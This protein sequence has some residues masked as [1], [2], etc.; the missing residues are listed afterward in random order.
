MQFWFTYPLS[1][2]Q[3]YYVLQDCL[4]ALYY[5]LYFLGKQCNADRLSGYGWGY[6]K[7]GEGVE[8][9]EGKDGTGCLSWICPVGNKSKHG[10]GKSDDTNPCGKKDGGKASPLQAFLTDCLPGFTCKELL[11]GG[12]YKTMLDKLRKD[13][14]KDSVYPSCYPEFLSHRGHT[15]VF[16]Q[17]CAVPMGFSGSFREKSEGGQPGQAAAGTANGSS[18]IG[19]GLQA[20]LAYYASSNISNASLYQIVRCI[21]SLT[22]RV[23]RSTGT[24]YGF[25]Y[26]LGQ[27]AFHRKKNEG[28]QEVNDYTFRDA[29]KDEMNCCP[30]WRD[31]TC[32]MDALMGWTE[33]D[34]ITKH[35]QNKDQGNYTLGS[36]HRCSN[37]DGNPSCGP[38]FQPLTG[39]L[40]NSVAPVF[41]ETYVSWIVHLTWRLQSGLQSLLDEFV[42]IDCSTSGCSTTGGSSSHCCKGGTDHGKECHCSDVVFC[43]G[44][45][46]LFYRFG[47]GYNSP[48]FLAGKID[49]GDKATRK[50][51]QFYDQLGNV[52]KGELFKK[53][54]AAINDFKYTTRLPFIALEKPWKL[55]G[56]SPENP[57]RWIPECETCLHHWILPGLWRQASVTGYCWCDLADGVADLLQGIESQLT[58]EEKKIVQNVL[59]VMGNIGGNNRIRDLIDNVASQLA[60]FIGYEESGGGGG[61]GSGVAGSAP[62]SKLTGKGIG[63]CGNKSGC[64]CGSGKSGC[65][66]KKYESKYTQSD[67]FDESLGGGDDSDD[68][69][70]TNKVREAK[71]RC[72]KILLGVIPFIFSGLSY[73]AWM[74]GSGKWNGNTFR[75][76]TKLL[77]HYISRMGYKWDQLAEKKDGK[78]VF[79]VIKSSGIL[80]KEDPKDKDYAQYLEKLRTEA[81]K[82]AQEESKE[83]KDKDKHSLLKL[84]ILCSGYFRS[85]HTIDSIRSSTP[86]L[87]RT[88][89]EILYWLT[90]LPYCPIYRTLVPKVQEMFR[91]NGGSDGSVTFYSSGKDCTITTDNCV[92][93]LLAAS[94]ASPFVLLTIQDTI[95]CLVGGSD[96]W[97]KKRTGDCSQGSP[98]AKSGNTSK[99]CPII[100]HDLYANSLFKFTYPL[101]ETQS[102]YLLQDNLFAL[103]YQ[104]YF[105]YKQGFWGISNGLGWGYCRYG[106]DVKCEN[107]SGWKCVAGAVSTHFSSKTV[108]GQDGNGKASP[109]QAFLC[110]CLPGF[111]CGEV[112]K[113]MKTHGKDIATKY[114]DCYMEFLEHRQ[115]VLDKPGQYCP[116]P[117]G[118]SGSFRKGTP[119]KSIGFQ[120]DGVVGLGINAGLYYYAQ[121]DLINSSLY[122]ITR[123][124]SSLTRRVPRSTGTLYGFFYGLVDVY[125]GRKGGFHTKLEDELSCCPGT[126][127]PDDLMNAVTNWRGGTHTEHKPGSHSKGT[128]DSLSGCNDKTATCGKYLH[129]LTG[130]LY[131][132]VAPQFCETYVSWIVHLT[133][134]L[135]EGFIEFRDTFNKIDCKEAGC[136]PKSGSTHCCQDGKSHSECSC[137]NVVKCAGVLALFYRFGFIYSNTGDLL[138]KKKQCKQFYEHLGTVIN[139]TAFK[140]LFSSINDFKYTTRLPFT[141]VIFSFWSIVLVYLVYSMAVNLDILHIQSHWRS[142]RS[143]LV[144]LQRLMADG[145]R[146]GFCILG[147][148]QEANGDR[149]LS[150]GVNDVYL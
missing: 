90:S 134:V 37:T 93:Y 129:P 137:E 48:A 111:T 96:E 148:F 34:H 70:S 109:L 27:V 65:T 147:Y 55:S 61:G 62:G 124:I 133:G 95:D 38:Y 135:K 22:R 68:D 91:V 12:E 115:H 78:E 126:R 6:C 142:P 58:P 66:G 36:L 8:C 59:D 140:D 89:R 100:L 49:D 121:N 71:L 29:L 81:G 44:V 87:P 110:D 64:T 32:L 2:T 136:G 33:S 119:L 132:S 73:M 28:K 75:N 146:K 88:V 18:M 102:Y 103:Y 74:A 114:S 42:K 94:L 72:A 123:C 127:D 9:D 130:S 23:P 141:L 41:C 98:G 112:V 101:S 76:N 51:S 105:L 122:Q 86:R 139:G 85:L 99:D 53:L 131:N 16:G 10:N 97:Q 144:P 63:C 80:G 145:S 5:Q 1:E 4:V 40:Y 92:T 52:V 118:F 107:V 17:E 56:S 69:N 31:P 84:N 13:G 104:C 47:F 7:Y 50:C 149:L 143:Y 79:K 19:L 60:K 15:K 39:S 67:K 14:D 3:S 45:S 138:S 116:I 54:F 83:E 20:V 125:S 25:F 120:G 26:G 77:H 113:K 150:Q 30:G 24:L 108:C 35:G 21:C 57:S 43:A 106:A 82:E 46:G 11:K 128:L 117:M